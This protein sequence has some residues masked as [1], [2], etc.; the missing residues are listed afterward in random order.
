M[1]I[2]ALNTTQSVMVALQQPVMKVSAV[3][4]EAIRQTR[5]DINEVRMLL[6]GN[7]ETWNHL[8][9]QA[10][11]EGDV[12]SQIQLSHALFGM[13]WGKDESKDFSSFSACDLEVYFYYPREFGLFN[14]A[15]DQAMGVESDWKTR[16]ARGEETFRAAAS[17]GY[18]PAFLEL[19]RTEWKWHASSY[20]FAV[21][22]RPFVGKGDK[23]LDYHFG[24][25]LKNGS[26]VGSALYYEGMYWMNQ[27]CGIPVKYPREHESFKDFTSRYI[28]FENNGNTFHDYDSFRHVGSSV[29]LAPSKEAWDAFVKE[30]LENVKFAPVES[31]SFA[32]DAAQILALLNEHKI[33]VFSGGSFVESDTEGRYIKDYRGKTLHGFCIITLTINQNHK[34]IGE[35]SVQEDTFKIYH[36]FQDPTLQPII[37]FIENVMTRTGSGH[38]AYE[39]LRQMGGRY[40]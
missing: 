22:L 7:V 4:L 28:L 12:V 14:A 18:L 13:K 29:V 35:I 5:G 1:S 15:Y 39:W 20:G 8:F 40:I 38:S 33:S 9:K 2:P 19:K 21:Q 25:A 34:E 32:F 10:V 11:E 6:K 30:K 3:S 17:R 16:D 37:D 24:Q 26:E 27:S 36:T 31:F 23:H